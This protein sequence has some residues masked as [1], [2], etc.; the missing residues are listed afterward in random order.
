[1]VL[2]NQG[3]DIHIPASDSNSSNNDYSSKVKLVKLNCH[4]WHDW[5]IRFE[6]L[7]I[8]KGHEEILDS[9]WIADNKESKTYWKKNSYPMSLLYKAVEQD[10]HSKIKAAKR[11][12]TQAY[13]ALA[14]ACG[15]S[16]M[17]VAGDMLFRLVQLTYKPGS[18]LREHTSRFKNQYVDLIE[19]VKGQPPENR[20]LNVPTGMAAVL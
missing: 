15:K 20:C 17:I 3:V 9:S 5:K 14:K 16:L 1:M 2:P 8:G 10:L 12:F 13:S 4:N 19:T 6:H 7:L 18:S 11:N